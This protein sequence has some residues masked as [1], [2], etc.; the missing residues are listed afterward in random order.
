[1]AQ[2]YAFG[3]EMFQ[4]NEGPS[5]PAHQFILS[6]TSTPGTADSGDYVSDFVSENPVKN[7]ALA[8]CIAISSTYAKIIDP[9]GTETPLYNLCY[10]HQTLT[11]LLDAANLTWRYYAPSEGSIWTAPTAINH[12]CVPSETYGSNDNTCSGSD[13]TA[14]TPKVVLNQTQ[15]NAQVLLDIEQLDPSQNNLQQ[16]SWVIPTGAD[17]DHAASNDG[18][19]PSWVTSIVNAIGVSP[20][21]PNTVI[22]ITWDDW[23]GWYDHVAPPQ[24]IDDGTSWGS[25][26]VYG[27]R[28]PL[29]V[30]SPYSKR[31]YISH[32]THD[33]GSIL[34][35]I[36]NNYGLGQI[37]QPALS[38]ADTYA[39]DAP[40]SLS[41]MFDFTS[42]P[43]PFTQISVPWNNTTC[44][45]DSTPS[46]PDDD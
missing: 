4:T 31:A 1:M 34:R 42:S 8:G 12:M 26:Y 19:G 23:G 33:F 9:T 29:I 13:Y 35:F 27:F 7:G 20:Y 14:A 22:I 32:T 11:D 3:D 37:G 45:S 6:G 30:I 36:E 18:C 46:D 21:W 2:T 43:Q 39:P 24:V 10:E 15:A 16:V 25:G 41:D 28:V 5:Y 44:Q 17:S 38:Y 40:N